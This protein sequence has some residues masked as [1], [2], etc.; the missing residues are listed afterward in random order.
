MAEME[1]KYHPQSAKK[2]VEALNETA[3]AIDQKLPGFSM[4]WEMIANCVAH[5]LYPKLAN[6][7]RSI[8]S[9]PI[10]YSIKSHDVDNDSI[11]KMIILLNQKQ[12]P[13]EEQQYL[14]KLCS[15]AMQFQPYSTSSNH[16]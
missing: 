15:R 5:E 12:V 16:S 13:I 3:R 4:N 6:T 1:Q 14:R 7:I 11:T 9:N 10:K 2:S 8:A